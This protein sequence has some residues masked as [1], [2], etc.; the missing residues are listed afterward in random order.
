[1][2][3]TERLEEVADQL[4][5][6]DTGGYVHETAGSEVGARDFV[7]RDLKD[8]CQVD[9]AYFRGAVPLVAFVEAGSPQDLGPAH[10]RLW[11]FGRVPVLI[12][13]MPQEVAAVSCVVPPAPEPSDGGSVLR[14]AR[15]NQPLQS[16]LQ[17]FTRF[18]IE[19]GHAAT[20]Y[21]QQFDRRLRVDYQLLGNLRR[22]RARLLKSNLDAIHVEQLI[23]RSIFIRYLEDRGI[24]TQER[25]LELGEFQSFVRTLGAGPNAVAQLFEA[26][27]QHF[28]GDVFALNNTEAYF[29]PQAI[30]DLF[31][32]FSGTDLKTG[33]QVPWPYD[34]NVIPPELISS[35]YE[36]LLAEKQRQYAAYYTPWHLVDLVLDE[37]V[38]WQADTAEPSI[39]D[40]SCGSGIF[41]AEAF[42]RFVYQHTMANED[43]L[44]FDDLSGLLTRC[45]YGVDS[46]PV[47]IGV[48]ALSLS[49]ALLEHIDPAAAWRDARLPE[50]VD[51]NL[52]VSDFFED[53]ALANR[54]FDFVVGNP[55]WMSALTQAAAAY[56][57]GQKME[58]PDQQ[59]A[60]VFLWRAV[61]L[62]EVGGAV[63]LVLP[64]KSLLHNRSETAEASRRHIFNDLNVETV[65]DLSPLRRETFGAAVGPASIVIVRG[66]RDD[67]D[68]PKTIHVSPR[69]TPL[70]DAIDGVVVSQEN[71]RQVP[72]AIAG[73]STIVWKT[74]L[75]GGPADFDL[76]TR[77]RENFPRLETVARK[78]DWIVGQGFQVKGGDQNDASELVGM[79][80]LLTSSVDTMRLVSAPTETV[81]D[82]IMHRPRDS[83]IYRAPHVIMRKGF[84]YY[85][86]SVFLD[87][88]AA[89]TDGLFA[90]AGPVKDAEELRVI[91]GLLNSSIAHY[92]F[93][94]TSSSWGIEREQIHLNEYLSLP[95]PPIVGSVRR[96]ILKA[97]KMAADERSNE[98]DWRQALDEAAFRAYGFTLSEEDLVRDGLDIKV[99]EYHRGPSSVAYEVPSTEEL[100][101]YCRVIESHLNTIESVR[102]NAEL[103]ERSAGFAVVACKA[104]GIRVSE[105]DFQFSLERLMSMSDTPLEG[106]MSP[107]VVMQPSVIIIEGTSVYL[108]KPDQRRSW[109]R[110]TARSDAAEVLSAILLAPSTREI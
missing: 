88:D 92:W 91:S 42:R 73:T 109:T 104:S 102:W 101:E 37:L 7:W 27:C 94:M 43:P 8:K 29:P 35:I 107:A 108:V 18:N 103:L 71:I 77:L 34:F 99:D 31:Q 10:R 93:F 33:Q 15:A 20:A 25:L 14:S 105:S 87:I 58:L 45:V 41:L 23:G 80:L 47:A 11:N 38:P 52:I 69:R 85:P 61:D 21:R 110:S 67:F 63:G 44:S 39:L 95:I 24:L 79:P 90:I 12:A 76:V 106:W 36:Q 84:R 26:L 1:M 46:S 16:V 75:W 6:R 19:N 2:A 98:H 64:A 59:I 53:H 83:R 17:E 68:L 100:A 55:P 78:N 81:T 49:L 70:A 40:P 54:R 50:L 66:H 57:L 32:F 56:V 30:D 9:A 65:V 89:F 97:V 62:T 4:G 13:S 48:S 3:Y 74:Y 86:V 28:N 5:Y 60:L 22:L 96:E 82:A 51:H 72:Q